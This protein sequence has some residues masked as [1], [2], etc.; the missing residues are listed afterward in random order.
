MV[1]TGFE[2]Q[3]WFGHI[4]HHCQEAALKQWFHRE[5]GRLIQYPVFVTALVAICLASSLMVETSSDMMTTGRKLM[6]VCIQDF[7]QCNTPATSDDKTNCN[8][9]CKNCH[10]SI[11]TGKCQKSYNGTC[12]SNGMCNCVGNLPCW[13][14]TCK[15]KHASKSNQLLFPNVNLRVFSYIENHKHQ[16]YT[17]MFYNVG[18]Y[19]MICLTNKIKQG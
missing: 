15:T 5:M 8:G 13:E 19:L 18:E 4:T 11:A 9:W 3:I 6:Q 10:A 17:W 2:L 7:V 14:L 16:K 1:L 12:L